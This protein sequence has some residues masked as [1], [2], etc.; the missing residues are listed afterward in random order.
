M[1]VLPLAEDMGLAALA[2]AEPIPLAAR[3]CTGLEMPEGPTESLGD[4]AREPGRDWAEGSGAL[5]ELG[6]RGLERQ[7]GGGRGRPSDMSM[8][9]L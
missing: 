7:G 5:Y 8:L 2:L 6:E 9:C 1:P 3:R 4:A